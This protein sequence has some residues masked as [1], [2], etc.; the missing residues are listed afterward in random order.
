MNLKKLRTDK[1]LTQTQI[2][3]II[4]TTQSVYSKYENETVSID[5]NSLKILSKLYNVSIDYIVDNDNRK[6]KTI[7]LN[8]LTETKKE[9]IQK[10]VDNNEK[11]ALKINAY[12]DVLTDRE[13]ESEIS[14]LK[15][16]D[17]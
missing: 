3:K 6:N 10:I 15:K 7:E 17:D 5:I 13:I 16:L 1:N 12:I 4:G 11:I 14:L 8:L 9:T 2:A